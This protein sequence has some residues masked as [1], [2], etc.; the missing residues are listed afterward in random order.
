MKGKRLE[1]AMK[2][3][4]L[5]IYKGILRRTVPKA[6]YDLLWAQTD[7]S[8]L[9]AWGALFAGPVPSAA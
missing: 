6:L 8:F 7:E 3:A 1:A 5:S 9:R 2:M 4:S